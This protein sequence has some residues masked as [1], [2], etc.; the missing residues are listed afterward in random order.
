MMC[1]LFAWLHPLD[2]LPSISC[3]SF[4][5]WLLLLAAAYIKLQ[6]ERQ[7]GRVEPQSTLPVPRLLREEGSWSESVSGAGDG[8]SLSCWSLAVLPPPGCSWPC[9]ALLPDIQTGLCALQSPCPIS[10]LPAALPCLCFMTGKMAEPHTRGWRETL[11][12]LKQ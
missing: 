6:G 8:W 3:L 11:W 12:P 2:F 4:H 1:T 10:V 7:G 5:S 9:W